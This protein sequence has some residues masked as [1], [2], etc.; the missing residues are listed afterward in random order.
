MQDHLLQAQEHITNANL[1]GKV[2]GRQMVSKAEN[3]QD[4]WS[5]DKS[6]MILQ[7]PDS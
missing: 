6:I 4:F 1:L 2:I 3:A 7:K 5:T